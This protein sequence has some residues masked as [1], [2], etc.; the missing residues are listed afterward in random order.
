MSC[1]YLHCQVRWRNPIRIP[2]GNHLETIR[3]WNLIGPVR[4]IYLLFQSL[5]SAVSDTRNQAGRPFG[6]Y[7]RHSSTRSFDLAGWCWL[8]GAR[9][10]AWAK[11]AG[12]VEGGEF[13]VRAAPWDAFVVIC[14]INPHLGLRPGTVTGRG[15]GCLRWLLDLHSVFNWW[16]N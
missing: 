16:I 7:S 15:C 6:D 12:F 10:F 11:E 13:C 3:S 4:T 9:W 14:S 8:G 2:S 1:N 5:S